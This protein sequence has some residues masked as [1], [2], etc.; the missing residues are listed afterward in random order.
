VKQRFFFLYGVEI[1]LTLC[2][3]DIGDEPQ[4]GQGCPP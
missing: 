3:K 4:G 1:A 2:K